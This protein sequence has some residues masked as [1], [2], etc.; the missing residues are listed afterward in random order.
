MCITV[1]IVLG[2]LYLYMR[3]IFIYNTVFIVLDII[4]YL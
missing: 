3:I 2:I 4:L 1:F